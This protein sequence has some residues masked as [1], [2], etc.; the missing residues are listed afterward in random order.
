MKLIADYPPNIALIRQYLDPPET[1]VF[2]YGNKIYVP[3]GENLDPDVVVHEEVHERQMKDYTSSDL[4]WLAYLSNPTYRLTCEL[5]AYG[6]Q[7]RWLKERITATD[8][9]TALGEM[10]YALSKHYNLNIHQGEAES[11]IKNFK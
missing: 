3:N 4:W 2:A 11:K 6:T 7:Y 1:A 8:L 9:K 5:E 10:G